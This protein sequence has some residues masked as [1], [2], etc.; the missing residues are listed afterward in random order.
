[1]DELSDD[2]FV[3]AMEYQ[4]LSSPVEHQEQLIPIDFLVRLNLL[5]NIYELTGFNQADLTFIFQKAITNIYCAANSTFKAN[6][7]ILLAL[8][9][10]RRYETCAGMAHKIKGCSSQTVESAVSKG[11][12]AIASCFDSFSILNQNQLFRMIDLMNQRETEVLI[13]RFKDAEAVLNSRFIVDCRHHSFSKVKNM[14]LG[15]SHY[16]SWKLKRAALTNMFI[17]DRC[18]FCRYVSLSAPATTSDVTLYRD[19][20]KDFVLTLKH[21]LSLKNIE[22]PIFVQ[23]DLGFECDLNS[24]ITCRADKTTE[25]IFNK[26]RILV[27][28]YF[29]RMTTKFISTRFPFKFK[30]ELHSDFIKAIAFLTN[31]SI[32][33]TA[34]REHEE[35]AYHLYI[36]ET[37]EI[38]IN[39]NKKNAARVKK[40]RQKKLLR[41]CMKNDR[42]P[43]KCSIVVTIDGHKI[44]PEYIKILTGNEERTLS[45]VLHYDQL[46]NDPTTSSDSLEMSDSSQPSTINENEEIAII[47]AT[48]NREDEEAEINKIA[49]EEL[50][51]E[52][53]AEASVVESPGLQFPTIVLN[54]RTPNRIIENRDGYFISRGIDSLAEEE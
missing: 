33:N 11:I 12:K 48:P 8:W 40:S 26:Y 23:G 27:E 13:E 34:L 17:I 24:I 1:M 4:L 35:K 41:K 47:D 22:E 45:Q 32:K 31:L 46:T 25:R 51:D 20:E 50:A 15:K 53:A 5:E 30:E 49:E 38:S 54:E 52:A 29:G 6:E 44:D 2:Y 3:R 16:Y 37:L 39:K 9:Y 28:Q 10:L 7:C 36:R 21:L 14:M 43:V 18:G 42:P 19:L